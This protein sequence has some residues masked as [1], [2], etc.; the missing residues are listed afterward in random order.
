M[1]ITLPCR[2]AAMVI[3]LS[4]ADLVLYCLVLIETIMNS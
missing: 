3:D 1:S 2:T 4:G